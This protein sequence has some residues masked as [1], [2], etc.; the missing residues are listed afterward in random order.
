MKHIKKFSSLIKFIIALVL[1][2]YSYLVQI[3]PIIIFNIDTNTTDPNIIY[4]LQIFSNAF[5]TIMLF[6]L[7]RKELIKEFKEFKNNF[8]DMSDVAM[9]YWLLGLIIMAAS[10][11]LISTFSP[12]KIANNEE[13]VRTIIAATPILAFF[14]T[15]VFAPINEEIVFRKSIK[16]VITEKIPYILTSGILFG[17]LHVI[18]SVTSFYDYLYIIPYSAL[19]IAFAC[20]NHKTNNIYPSI[21]V[22]LLHN[23][24]LTILS[25]IGTGMII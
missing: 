1:F 17:A 6:L 22:H 23:G 24:V 9:K 25:I 18:S 13:G 16:N 15:T 4:A 8:W 19:G 3:I 7:Y 10:N 2:F 11:I 5:L 12:A 14:L 20:I 21:F